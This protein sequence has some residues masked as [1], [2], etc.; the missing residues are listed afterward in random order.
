MPR[1]PSIFADLLIES[2]HGAI[3]AAQAQKLLDV[4]LE[5]CD[6]LGVADA[7][8]ERASGVARTLIALALAGEKEPA[9]LRAHTLAAF[10]PQA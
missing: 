1:T 6:A 10:K 8:D 9:A 4:F 7:E 3:D 5:V 2:G